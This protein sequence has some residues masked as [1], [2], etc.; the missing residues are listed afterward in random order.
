MSAL[1][2]YRAM[3]L[4]GYDVEETWEDEGALYVVVSVLRESLRC[5]SCGCRRCHRDERKPRCWKAAP[6]GLKALF[7]AMGVPA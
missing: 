5:R 7:V 3:G 2:L 4:T 1:A 6:L